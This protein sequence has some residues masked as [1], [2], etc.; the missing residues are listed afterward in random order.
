MSTTPE[1]SL[2]SGGGAVQ[3]LGETFQPDFHTGTGSY[4]IP[5]DIPNGP[6][7]IAPK[8]TLQYHTA[9]GNGPF[10]MG[11][12]LPVLAIARSLERRVPTYRDPDDMLVL[13][14]G[15]ELVPLGDGGFRLR[16]DTNGW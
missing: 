16:A 13:L 7:D 10:G 9:A 8:L 15:G 1:L 12:A 2:P 3:G 14:G 11:F 5:L 6:N 4:A